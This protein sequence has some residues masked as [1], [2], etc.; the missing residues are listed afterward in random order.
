MLIYHN[1]DMSCITQEE[2]SVGPLNLKDKLGSYRKGRELR[3][4]GGTSL[5]GHRPKQWFPLSTPSGAVVYPYRNDGEEGHWRWGKDQKMKAILADPEIAHWE[6]CPFDDGVTV[7]SAH[8][9]WVPFEKIRDKKKAVGWGTWLDQIGFNSDATRELK[10]IF[11]AKPFDTPKPTSL[12]EWLVSLHSNDQAIVLDSFAGSGTTAHAVLKLN[13]QDGGN[14]RFIL[15]EMMEYAETLTAERVRRVM[16][17]YGEGAK[18]VAGLGGGF[19]YFTI[20][21][22]LFDEDGNLSSAAGIAAIRDYVAYTEGIPSESRAAPDNAVSPYYL[23]EAQ[24]Q[25]VF[26]AY[27]ADQP[28]TLDLDMLALLVKTP[29]RVLIYADQCAL[30]D[31]FM[32]RHGIAFKKIPRDVSRL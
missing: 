20:G 25:R 3:K 21:P 14:R 26:F 2:R 7:D 6:L 31:A 23:G 16:A 12:I 30:G 4:W 11:G 27:E 17:G 28:T 22:A 19:E 1:G 32:R 18:T 8:E 9:R 13:A 24:G 10:E 5:R 29:G 15:V